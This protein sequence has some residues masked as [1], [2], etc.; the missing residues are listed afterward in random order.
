[1]NRTN[2]S[3]R[4]PLFP[5]TGIRGM[6]PAIHGRDPAR[7][8]LKTGRGLGRRPKVAHPRTPGRP[9]RAGATSRTAAPLNASDITAAP[10]SD[11]TTTEDVA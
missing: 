2:P 7:T 4:P 11:L 5:Y 10:E 6:R 9:T 8:E 1:M 3:W